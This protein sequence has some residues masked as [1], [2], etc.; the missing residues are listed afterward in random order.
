MVGL[1]TWKVATVRTGIDANTPS[2][3]TAP[4]LCLVNLRVSLPVCWI[5]DSN[6][7]TQWDPSEMPSYGIRTRGSMVS[8]DSRGIYP[9]EMLANSGSQ[10]GIMDP[11]YSIFC[12][13]I[14]E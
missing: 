12:S 13:S 5:R 11:K 6:N 1:L 7:Q 10:R 2:S 3:Q 14:S 9:D 8:F 4:K